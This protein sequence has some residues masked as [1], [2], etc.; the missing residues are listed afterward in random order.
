MK[1]QTRH[2]KKEEKRQQHHIKKK[3]K[4]KTENSEISPQIKTITTRRGG[5]TYF[6]K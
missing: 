4:K 3:I 5:V 2:K 6:S 1:Q